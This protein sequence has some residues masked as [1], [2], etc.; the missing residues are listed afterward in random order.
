[1][2]LR[3]TPQQQV[4][5][6]LAV[7]AAALLLCV[8]ILLVSF[9]RFGRSPIPRTGDE[10][11]LASPAR[12]HLLAPLV[13]VVAFGIA[14]GPLVGAVA[15]AVTLL[16]VVLA[17]ARWLLGFGAAVALAAAGAYVALQ[18]HRYGYPPDFAWPVNVERAA[19]LGWLSVALLAGSALKKT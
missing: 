10:P 18:Q 14:A 17:P 12:P 6:G 11:E 5:T 8:L 16:A 3:W 9:V 2:H 13:V 4:W 19:D 15:G 1:V 7:S